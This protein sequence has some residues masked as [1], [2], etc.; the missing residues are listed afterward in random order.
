MDWLT[1]ILV[2]ATWIACSLLFGFVWALGHRDR[3][4]LWEP[5]RERGSLMRSAAEHRC[6]VD[7]PIEINLQ[8]LEAVDPDELAR[9]I[10]RDL[11]MAIRNRR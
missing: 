5:P 1:I 10:T 6:R 9:R 7:P 8:P 11:Q 3:R 2:L 4:P